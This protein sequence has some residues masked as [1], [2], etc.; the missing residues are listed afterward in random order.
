MSLRVSLDLV[1]YISQF[2][3][4]AWFFMELFIRIFK[5]VI[6][7]APTNMIYSSLVIGAVIG[8]G[9]FCAARY[10]L[11]RYDNMPRGESFVQAIYTS[12]YLL[13][14]W[15]PLVVFIGFKIL[16]MKKDM[17]WGKTAHG[18][19]QHEHAIQR[20]KE[21]IR[22]AKEELKKLIRAN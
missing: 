19:V 9:F 11:R 15:F 17:N 12:I 4:P 16:F 10:S 6:K 2:L 20:A 5:I 7:D 8:F 3:M 1:A 21:K 14:I 13:M 18:L 22:Q